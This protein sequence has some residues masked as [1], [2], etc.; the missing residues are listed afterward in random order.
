MQENKRK[1]AIGKLLASASLVFASASYVIWHHLGQAAMPRA[2]VARSHPHSVSDA[3]AAYQKSAAPVSIAV[4]RPGHT[5]PVHAAS[6]AA[7]TPG[8]TR[9][10]E[11]SNP[12]QVGIAAPSPAASSRAAPEPAPQIAAAAPPA[13]AAPA[14]AASAAGC[15][16]DLPAPPSGASAAYGGSRVMPL[17]SDGEFTGRCAETDWGHLQVRAIV[18]MGLMVDV[19]FLL[20]PEARS[21]SMEI[22]S[23][24][25]PILAEEAIEKQSAAV[26]IVT[27]ATFTSTGFRNSLASALLQ[28]KVDRAKN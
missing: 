28:A 9:A 17:F 19:Q 2:M 1:S 26:D 12:A 25:L 15:S 7:G 13:Q 27:Q 20:F 3:L 16:Y 11:D 14:P 24:A 10:V 4:S 5:A 18:K 22:S 6:P 8:V 21:Q 23:W